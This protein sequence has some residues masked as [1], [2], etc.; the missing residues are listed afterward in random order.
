[1]Y[2]AVV[3][4]GACTRTVVHTSRTGTAVLPAPPAMKRTVRSDAVRTTAFCMHGDV[5]CDGAL[6]D[7]VSHQQDMAKAI[8]CQRTAMRR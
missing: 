4:S 1:M 6:P 5:E 7:V 2:Q 3:G 8:V